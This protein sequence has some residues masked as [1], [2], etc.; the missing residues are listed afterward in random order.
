MLK[1]KRKS[2]RNKVS[3]FYLLRDEY[4]QI[5]NK[6]VEMLTKMLILYLFTYN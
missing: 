4:N 5:L 1:G 6:Y 2:Y 3:P